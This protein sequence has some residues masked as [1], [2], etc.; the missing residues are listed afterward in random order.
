MT[1][2]F[3]RKQQIRPGKTDRLRELLGSI[4]DE[5]K[6]DKE[7]VVGIWNAET[8]QTLSMFIEHG[9][10]AD[11]LVWYIEATDMETLIKARETSTHR[12]H[13]IEDELMEETLENPESV[14]RFEPLVHGVNPNRS[15]E[16]YLG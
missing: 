9:D 2:V 5:A 13:D 12:L 1:E 16:F 10:D 7:D 11:Y 4:I 8:L 15:R 6:D 3:I 14:S